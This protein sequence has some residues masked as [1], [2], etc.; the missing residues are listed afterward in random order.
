MTRR[1]GVLF[2]CHY[3]SRHFVSASR[4]ATLP[5][6]RGTLTLAASVDFLPNLHNL[7]RTNGCP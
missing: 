4:R 5:T 6:F 1:S 7:R 3:W 2:E